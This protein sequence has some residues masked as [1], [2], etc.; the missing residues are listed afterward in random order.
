M[1][2]DIIIVASVLTTVIAGLGAFIAK[3]HIKKCSAG[4]IQSDCVSPPSSPRLSEDKTQP[5]GFS[6]IFRMAKRLNELEIEASKEIKEI[7][8]ETTI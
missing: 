4:C 6:R 2:V 5:R 7:K 8:S 1:A 3:L